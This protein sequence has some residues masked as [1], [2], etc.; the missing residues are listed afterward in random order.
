MAHP[1]HETIKLA[2]DEL[3]KFIYEVT[4]A[5]LPVMTELTPWEGPQ[6]L[7]GDSRRVR[8]LGIDI[9]CENLGEE[10]FILRT[11][12]SSLVL[13]GA[14]P[15]GTLYSVYAFLE[16]EVGCRWFSSCVSHIPHK[17]VL[18]INN[19][20]YVRFPPSSPGRPTGGMPLT[21]ILPCATA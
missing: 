20:I 21:V 6:L 2:A 11:V 3:H 13:A 16:E 7:V 9:A 4:G 10:G 17:T 1:A 15:R 14:T 19:L 12:G 18:T 8:E 5:S